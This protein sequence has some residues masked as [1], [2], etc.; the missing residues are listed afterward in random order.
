MTHPAQRFRAP[1]SIQRGQPL[2]ALFDR[3][4]V[5]LI[6][7]SFAA[8]HAGFAR[9]RFV[10]QATAGLAELE[11][12]PRAAHIAQAL[13]AALPPTPDAA[14]E[15]LIAALGP[16]LTVTEGYGLAPF[17]YL[18]H[19]A[20]IQHHLIADGAAGMRANYAVTKRFSAEFSVRPYL[21]R[22]PEP[23]LALFTAWT[24]DPNPHVRRL[25]SE[26]SRPRLPW[27][28]RLAPFQRDPTPTIALLERL[29]DDS[30]AYVRR[31][32][33]NHVGDIAKDHPERAFQLCRRWLA[34]VGDDDT[35]AARR[36]LIRHALRLPAQRGDPTALRLRRAAGGR[37]TT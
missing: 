6:G 36:A 8:V 29:K 15:V 27:A 24:A 37:G 28:G 30:S 32:V 33:A 10:A 7:E 12:M 34:E 14:A 23:T 17:F 11:L 26:G 2:K 13:T 5:G 1:S 4:A 19:V 3:E 21:L 22:H 20:F 16:E 9:D 18:P 31:S 35:G 25:V